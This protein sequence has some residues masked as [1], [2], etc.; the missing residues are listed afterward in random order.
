MFVYLKAHDRSKNVLDDRMPMVNESQ[1]I[2]ADWTEFY[3]DAEEAIPPNAPEPKGN[4]GLVSCFV[5]ADH[6]GKKII[7]RLHTG[8]IIFINCAPIVWFSK[9]QNTLE[10]STFGSA[11]IAARIAVDLIEALCYK[12]RMFGVLIDDP[13]NLYCDNEAVVTNSSHPE[14]QIK[15][16]YNAIAYHHVKEAVAAGIICIGKEDSKSNIADMLAK[17]LPSEQLKNLCQRCMY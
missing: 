2:K 5:D 16:K 13:T 11:F 12:L 14:S 8:I 15:K 9:K 6:A 4:S 10:S 3:R 17:P 7:R 1:F